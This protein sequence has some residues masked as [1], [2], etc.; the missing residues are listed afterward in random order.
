[1]PHILILYSSIVV[2]KLGLFNSTK[3]IGSS[4]QGEQRAKSSRFTDA[5]KVVGCA[6]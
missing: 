5:L 3:V 2:K 4:P 6:Q 1:M